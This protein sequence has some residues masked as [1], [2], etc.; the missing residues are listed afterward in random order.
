[1]KS[2]TSKL[3]KARVTGRKPYG[4]G[5]VSRALAVVLVETGFWPPSVDFTMKDLNTVLDVMKERG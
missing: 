3:W 2:S 4:R 5:S 1:M